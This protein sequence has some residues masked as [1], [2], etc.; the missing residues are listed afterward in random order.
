MWLHRAHSRPL[1]ECSPAQRR[2][3]LA[4]HA[5]PAPTPAS[6][7][8]PPPRTECHAAVRNASARSGDN[9][10]C[11]ARALAYMRCGAAQKLLALLTL[12]FFRFE[13]EARKA[14]AGPRAR[15]T[16]RNAAENRV[17]TGRFRT[18]SAGRIRRPVVR[19]RLL[20]L[21]GR[22]PFSGARRRR[23]ALSKPATKSSVPSGRPVCVLRRIASASASAPV[24]L[25][26]SCHVAGVQESHHGCISREASAPWHPQCAAALDHA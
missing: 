9:S 10:S 14:A 25:R 6:A 24:A 16:L 22:P 18:L 17:Q 11:A 3:S 2:A 20:I 19:H 12:R 4:P 21:A 7:A 1:R 15:S 8:R 26:Y 13:R 5:P 23:R